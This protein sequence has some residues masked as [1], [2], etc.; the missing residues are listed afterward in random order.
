MGGKVSRVLVN[1]IQDNTYY[2]RI[3]LDVEGR[4]AEVDSRPSD[5]IALAIR[6]GCPIFIDESVIEQAGLVLEEEPATQNGAGEERLDVFRDFFSQLGP[7]DSTE[8]D[9]PLEKV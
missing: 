3:I 7:E 5:A 6:A 8:S 1:D 9:P 4:Y 2:A